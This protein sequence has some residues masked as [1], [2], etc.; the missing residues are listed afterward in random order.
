MQF[1]TNAVKPSRIKQEK[2]KSTLQQPTALYPAVI[3]F[4]GGMATILFGHELALMAL[5][6]G[7]VVAVS[8]WAWE[9]FVK[10][11]GHAN[12]YLDAYRR[13]LKEQREQ[14]ITRLRKELTS[15]GAD[16]GNHQ[17][18]LFQAKFESFQQ[19]LKRK[20]QPSELTFNRYLAT[21]EQVYLNGLDN[22]EKVALALGSI[23][24][25]DI[26][27]LDQNILQSQDKSH[28]TSAQSSNESHTHL[29]ERRQLYNQQHARAS[30]LYAENEGALTRLDQVSTL[31]ANTDFSSGKAAMDMEQAI[32]EL[33]RLI[34]TSEDYDINRS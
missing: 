10:G 17:L 33:T 14:S 7:G 6:T 16:R 2:L 20:L 34:E 11:E 27:K 25:I 31:L 15:L 32:K 12:R 4:L 22:L 24:A 8:G 23:S 5:I 1:D 29:L 28:Q 9:F 30:Q 18:D 19:I 3:A 13:Q 21:A 26:A